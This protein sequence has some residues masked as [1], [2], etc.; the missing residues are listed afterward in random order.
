MVYSKVWLGITVL[1][2]YQVYILLSN[3][4][5]ARGLGEQYDQLSWIYIVCFA[6]QVI[7]VSISMEQ[8]Q[9]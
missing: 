1:V 5:G 9:K 7:H 6:I 4:G 3:V 8:Q 2:M